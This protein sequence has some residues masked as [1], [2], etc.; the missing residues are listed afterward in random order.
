MVIQTQGIYKDLFDI[1]YNRLEAWTYV[2]TSQALIEVSAHIKEYQFNENVSFYDFIE[3]VLPK[4]NVKDINKW[5]NL[6]AKLYGRKNKRL[7]NTIMENSFDKTHDTQ[8]SKVCEYLF[9]KEGLRYLI[10]DYTSFLI[11]TNKSISYWHPDYS[12]VPL[13]NELPFI[14]QKLIEMYF[15]PMFLDEH[16]SLLLRLET[17]MHEAVPE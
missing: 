13:Y 5:Q 8:L 2:D 7:F 17:A 6:C 14:Q 1:A 12:P 11:N 15:K 3:K 9:S 10:S 4:I 16:L